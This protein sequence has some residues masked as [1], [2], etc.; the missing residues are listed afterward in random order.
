VDVEEGGE[1]DMPRVKDVSEMEAVC[2]RH[3]GDKQS[4]L[5]DGH[6]KWK[7]VAGLGGV[8]IL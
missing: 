6:C 7:P 3:N 8:M 2:S 5:K 4:C 1:D